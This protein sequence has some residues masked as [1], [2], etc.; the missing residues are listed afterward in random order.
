V[1]RESIS[2]KLIPSKTRRKEKQSYYLRRG[3]KLHRKIERKKKRKMILTLLL[4]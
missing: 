3:R 1:R 4:S 2:F